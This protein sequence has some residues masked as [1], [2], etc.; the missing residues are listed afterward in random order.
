M[1]G[2]KMTLAIGHHKVVLSKSSMRMN[3]NQN[4]N[5]QRAIKKPTV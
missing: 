5:V 4:A 1:I 3:E 2:D